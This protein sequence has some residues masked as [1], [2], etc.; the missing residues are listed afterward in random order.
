MEDREY[1]IELYEIYKELLTVKQRNYFEAYYFNDLSLSEISEN[2]EVSRA[3][4]GKTINII[5]SK[6]LKLENILKVREKNKIIEKLDNNKS[7]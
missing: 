4:I 1:I 2:L 7:N 6:L 3:I 5:K